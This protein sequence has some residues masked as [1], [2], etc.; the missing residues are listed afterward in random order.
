MHHLQWIG[1]KC[2]KP[3]PPISTGRRVRQHGWVYEVMEMNEASG[4]AYCRWWAKALPSG[5]HE[6]LNIFVLTE[7]SDGADGSGWYSIPVGGSPLLVHLNN[8]MCT[9]D[10]VGA[11]E[12]AMVCKIKNV[13]NAVWVAACVY[14][15]DAVDRQEYVA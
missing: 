12:L 4:W 9:A 14:K 3:G 13:M 10:V 1:L 2:R 6:R 15:L 7:E 8:S 5:P 11:V